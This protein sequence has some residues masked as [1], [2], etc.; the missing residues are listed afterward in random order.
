[1][2]SSK[3]P[4][5]RLSGWN[6]SV[7]LRVKVRLFSHSVELSEWW[8]SLK[9]NGC[10]WHACCADFLIISVCVCVR[11]CATECVVGNQ[12][13]TSSCQEN[14]KVSTRRNLL[15]YIM[16]MWDSVFN[17]MNI[18][19]FFSWN[20]TSE[21]WCVLE[22]FPYP[23][24]NVKLVSSSCMCSYTDNRSPLAGFHLFSASSWKHTQD[25]QKNTLRHGKQDKEREIGNFRNM[26]LWQTVDKSVTK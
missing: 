26:I 23:L 1:M 25:R 16:V 12:V 7:I 21:R 22:H 17:H 3:F 8:L 9:L 2:S 19:L 20:S 15:I 18:L 13:H 14:I 24:D 4:T 10:L 6:S 11:E 5:N